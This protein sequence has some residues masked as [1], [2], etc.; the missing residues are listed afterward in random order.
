MITKLINIKAKR[1]ALCYSTQGLPVVV[2]Q[3]NCFSKLTGMNQNLFQHLYHLFESCYIYY[4]FTSGQ[5]TLQLS[6]S[7]L[8]FKTVYESKYWRYYKSLDLN[9]NSYIYLGTEK[10]S[11]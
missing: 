8:S 9:L 5:K 7:E 3:T 1:H 10:L 6:E 11:N 2:W 4:K